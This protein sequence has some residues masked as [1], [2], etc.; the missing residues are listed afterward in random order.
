MD[1]AI[2][3]VAK[4]GNRKT[5]F[6]L[7]ASRELEQILQAGFRV[8][9]APSRSLVLGIEAAASSSPFTL[10]LQ[11]LDGIAGNSWF[12]GKA[13]L[14]QG[15]VL[16]AAMIEELASWASIEVAFQVGLSW[17]YGAGSH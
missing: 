4:A 16:E 12:G 11:Y 14:G 9:Y 7:Q 6:L 15:L 10:R 2:P 13:R 5:E 1:V 17:E 3:G 8:F